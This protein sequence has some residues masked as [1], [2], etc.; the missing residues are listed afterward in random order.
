M[1]GFAMEF[2]ALENNFS[3]I[4]SPRNFPFRE[5]HN[6]WFIFSLHTEFSLVLL[7]TGMVLSNSLQSYRS[8]TCQLSA[9]LHGRLNSVSTWYKDL[10]IHIF[11]SSLI[12]V[13]ALLW[14]R[15]LYR[16]NPLRLRSTMCTCNMNLEY[17]ASL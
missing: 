15:G 11:H 3:F 9:L 13:S 10:S 17:H 6:V 12:F 2:F 14:G 7:P 5:E 16:S 1:V 4:C 8:T